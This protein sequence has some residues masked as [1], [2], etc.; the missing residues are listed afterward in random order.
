MRARLHSIPE[1][2]QPKR[3]DEQ[4]CFCRGTDLGEDDELLARKL[5]ILDGSS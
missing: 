4:E 5:E 3:R 1:W 2:A